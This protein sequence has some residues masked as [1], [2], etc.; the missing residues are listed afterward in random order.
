MHR[1][2]HNHQEYLLH[3]NLNWNHNLLARTIYL[4]PIEPTTYSIQAPH[5][6]KIT[7]KL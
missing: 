1:N 6:P 7:I 3:C 5:P 2:N 4:N